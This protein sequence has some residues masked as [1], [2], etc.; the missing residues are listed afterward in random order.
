MRRANYISIL[1]QMC[2][3]FK[4]MLKNDFN[5]LFEFHGSNPRCIFK[6]NNNNNDFIWDVLLQINRGGRSEG[7]GR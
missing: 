7:F 1:V 4:M 6:W 5:V 2:N 3:L